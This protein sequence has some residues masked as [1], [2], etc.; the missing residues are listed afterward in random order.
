MTKSALNKDGVPRQMQGC[1][2]LVIK[3]KIRYQ[4][5]GYGLIVASLI[6]L[7]FYNGVPYLGKMFW[8]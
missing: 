8:P 7:A 3:E 1:N 5:K 4:R 6:A 2:Q